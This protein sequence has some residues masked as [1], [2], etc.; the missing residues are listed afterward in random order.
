[1][2]R[3]HSPRG[4]IYRHSHRSPASDPL[5]GPLHGDRDT[6]PGQ[7]LLHSPQS[8]SLQKRA[9]GEPLLGGPQSSALRSEMTPRSQM[10]CI[11]WGEV[12]FSE[13]FQENSK[14]GKG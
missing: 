1:M 14:S 5:T 6:Q 3:D 9:E 8:A 10:T 2:P 12:S 13:E 11:P 7:S 4:A